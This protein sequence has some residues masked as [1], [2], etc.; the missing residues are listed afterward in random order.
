MTDQNDPETTGQQPGDPETIDPREAEVAALT[1]RLDLALRTLAEQQ[2][3]NRRLEKEKT[4]AAAY[5]VTNFARDLVD[6]ADN[7]G[8]ALTSL[9]ADAKA[10]L[11]GPVR[12]FVDGIEMVDRLFVQVLE[13]HG[14]S[15]LDPLGQKFDPNHHQA[16]M[17]VESHEAEPGTVVIVMQPGYR[18]KDRLLR[19]AMVGVAKA[20][21]GP[22]PEQQRV[23]TTA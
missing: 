2:N 15:R 23:D 17:E 18:I 22:K 4:D 9:S 16:M 14:M 5:S 11:E 13:R 1:E 20:A 21:S 12:T 8:R 6:V 7:F 3:M 19:P 10:G